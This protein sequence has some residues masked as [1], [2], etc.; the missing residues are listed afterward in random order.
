MPIELDD[1]AY[2]VVDLRDGYHAYYASL[3]GH[4]RRN[5]GQKA[6]K[7]AAAGFTVESVSPEEG[8]DSLER[9]IER[10]IAI[11]EAS[12]KLEGRPLA[13][14]H[15]GFLADVVRRLG[16]RGIL[17]LPILSIGGRDAAVHVQPEDPH[18]GVLQQLGE[19]GACGGSIHGHQ[20]GGALGAGV[21]PQATPRRGATL[22]PRSAP[23][24]GRSVPPDPQVLRAQ[25]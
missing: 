12:Y 19:I 16:R 22:T 2:A 24:R 17:S 25:V 5:L 14:I 4:Y 7:I 1:H 3:N 10:L 13:D 23:S 9:S 20:V 21:P 8:P 15:K 6:R 11:N 18:G